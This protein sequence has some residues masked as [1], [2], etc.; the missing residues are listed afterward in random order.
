[1]LYEVIT[2][3][4]EIALHSGY[5]PWHISKIFKS[6]TGKT[7]FEYM[8]SLRLSEAALSLRDEDTQIIDIALE[9][10]FDTHEGF[11]RA[12]AKEFGIPPKKY[13]YNFV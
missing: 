6:Y 7:I 9:F 5:S 10:I 13:S 12:F 4:H 1:M 2:S 11:T 3:L 8:R